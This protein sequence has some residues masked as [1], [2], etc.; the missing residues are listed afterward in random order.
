MYIIYLCRSNIPPSSS[1]GFLPLATHRFLWFHQV[2]RV[3]CSSLV[4]L[5]VDGPKATVKSIG[6]SVGLVSMKFLLVPKNLIKLLWWVGTFFFSFWTFLTRIFVFVKCF[7]SMWTSGW[8]QGSR[9]VPDFFQFPL[10]LFL[11]CRKGSSWMVCLEA[12]ELERQ[13]DLKLEQLCIY[14]HIYIARCIYIYNYRHTYMCKW[15]DR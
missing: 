11:F 4:Q 1:L 12:G 5:K 2:R 3:I 14:I 7:E 6:V 9:S 15:H 8:I 10:R 13:N